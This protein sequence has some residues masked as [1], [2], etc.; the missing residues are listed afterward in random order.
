MVNDIRDLL[1]NPQCPVCESEMKREGLQYVCK[2]GFSA[3]PEVAKAFKRVNS[4]FGMG[5]LDDIFGG[6]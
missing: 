5:G 2:C 1:G 6:F 4:G 3:P